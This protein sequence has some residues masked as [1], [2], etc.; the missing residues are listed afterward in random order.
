MNALT[1][2]LLAETTADVRTVRTTSLTAIATKASKV[3][4]KPAK[5]LRTR[6]SETIT[7][8][9]RNIEIF[10]L[11]FSLRINDLS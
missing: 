11:L 10:I 9:Q 5:K 2:G 1:Q 3:S 7:C 4:I 8:S 6:S